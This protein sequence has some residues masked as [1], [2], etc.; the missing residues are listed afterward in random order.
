M[1]VSANKRRRDVEYGVGDLVYLRFR[2]HR[3]ATLF[4]ARNRKLAPRYFGPFRIEARIG[5]TAYRLQLP[6]SSRIHPVFH[7][8]LLKR[9]IGEEVADP[10]L[11]DGVV[12]HEPPFLPEAVLDRRSVDREGDSV[13]QVLVKWGDLDEEE[14][15]WMDVADVQGQFPF[16]SLEDKAVSTGE[17]VNTGKSWRVYKR[18]DR[19]VVWPAEGNKEAAGK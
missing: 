19:R 14:A 6:V 4:S 12:E 3:Q 11:P 18:G 2:P 1:T 9:A 10:T 16:F 8:S 7:V 15:T 13:D 17:A 5:S